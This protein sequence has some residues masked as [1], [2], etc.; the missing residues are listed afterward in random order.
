MRSSAGSK[1]I[2]HVENCRSSRTEG[3][4]QLHRISFKQN[5]LVKAVGISMP[6]SS[7]SVLELADFD[8][9]SNDCSGYCGVL[10]PKQSRLQDVRV[11]RVRFSGSANRSTAVFYASS[12]SR[13]SVEYMN[14]VEN[15]CSLLHIKGGSLNLWNVSF[16]QNPLN[17]SA[18]K[19]VNPCIRLS[20]ASALIRE[21]RFE[22]NKA[23]IG[24]AIVTSTSNVT[25]MNTSFERNAA[26]QGGIMV[27][28]DSSSALIQSCNF[29][30]NIADESGGV[31]LAS[32]SRVI[33]E[34]STLKENRA[35]QLGGC[36]CLKSRSELEMRQSTLKKNEANFGGI[37]HLAKHSMANLSES[38]LHKNDAVTSGGCIYLGVSRLFVQKC[39]F[40]SGSAVYGGGIYASS[41]NV[42]VMK[43][44]VSKNNASTSGGFVY[45]N[46]SKLT[47][48]NCRVNDGCAR[49]GGGICAFS[50]EISA[51]KIIA[52]RNNAKD[53][54][55]FFCGQTSEVRTS[56][57]SYTDNVATTGGGVTECRP[58]CTFSDI[59]SNYSRNAADFG[60]AIYLKQNATGSISDCRFEKNNASISGGGVY[61]EDSAVLS[62][63]KCHFG[64]GSAQFGGGIYAFF[65]SVSVVKT[66]VSRNNVSDH[67]G[68]IYGG[69]TELRLSDC[70]YIDNVAGS[71]GGVVHCLP[72]CTYSDMRSNYSRNTAPMG[73]SIYLRQN[74]SGSITECTFDKNNASISGGVAHIEG[75][76]LF[77]RKC[78]FA[79]G[80]AHVGGGISLLYS[81]ISV[82]K[83]TASGL[84][85]TETGGF[86]AG[87]TSEIVINDCSFLN[88]VAG[89]GGVLS[90]DPNC[91]LNLKRSNCSGNAADF[92]A[93]LYL[94]A[95]SSGRI[96]D[97][98]FEKN[99]ASTSGG[100]AYLGVSTLSVQKCRFVSGSA[101]YGGGICA[102]DSNV[103]II[104][105]TSRRSNA[106]TSGGFVYL[107]DSIFSMQ[108][109]RLVNGSANYGGGIYAFS[110][111]VSVMET[112]AQGNNA[113]EYGGGIYVTDSL[114]FVRRCRFVNGSTDYG[115]GICAYDSN[116]SIIETTSRRSNASTSGGF[117]YLEDSIFSM[118]KCRLVNGSANYGG[119]IY[120]FSSNVS[121]METTAQ[122]N[123]ASEYGGGIY[124]T[125]SLLFVRRCRFVNGSTD[126]GGGICAYDSNV[127]IIET[128]SRRSNASTSGG[129]VYLEDSIFSMQKCRLV[130]GSAN[131]GGGICAYDSNVSVIETTASNNIAS[132]SGGFVYLEDSIFSMQ[133]CRLVNGSANYGGGIYAASSKISVSETIASSLSANEEG[134]FI[135]G[136]NAE[137]LIRDC[138]FVHNTAT[139]AGGVIRCLKNS[140]LVVKKSNYSHN[141]AS[142]GGAIYLAQNSSGRLVNSGFDKNTARTSGGAAYIESSGL[143]VQKC[144][145]TGGSA[146]HGGGIYG[147]SL[148]GISIH[149]TKA[150]NMSALE[151]G[152]FIS[153][154]FLSSAV[155]VRSSVISATAQD[156]GAVHVSSRSKFK[157]RDIRISSC[158]AE[159]N[160]GA[161]YG[162]ASHF[163]CINCLVENNNGRYGGAI[164]SEYSDPQ[165][166]ELQLEN[167]TIRNNSAVFGGI[168]QIPHSL[169]SNLLF[170]GGIEVMAIDTFV[171]SNRSIG[172]DDCYAAALIDNV[173]EE[174][175]ATVAGGAVFVD[176]IAVIRMHCS[177]NSTEDELSFLSDEQ[178]KQMKVLNSTEDIC[179]TWKAN[180]AKRYG[181]DVASYA[182]DV[183]KI[184]HSMPTCNISAVKNQY[185]VHNYSSG[186]PLPPVSLTS[187][188]DLGQH[189]AFGVDN[190]QVAAVMS[191]PDGLFDGNIS[192]RLD[193][194]VESFTTIGFAEPG[195]YTVVIDFDQEQCES[196]KIVVEV[197]SCAMGE[198]PFRNGTLCE[199]CSSSTYSLSLEGDSVCHPCPENG[200][201]ETRVILPN[202]GYW[203]RTPCSEHIDRCIAR[204]ACVG[205][206]RQQELVEATKEVETCDFDEQY[207]QN[208]TE[209]QCREVRQWVLLRGFEFRGFYLQGHEGPLCGSC[210]E[211]CGRSHSFLCQKCFSDTGNVILVC[212]SF[213][214][215]MGLSAITIRSNL[216]SAA[217]LLQQPQTPMTAS[218]AST[219][220]HPVPTARCTMELT[221]MGR[222]EQEVLHHAQGQSVDLVRN[223]QD[224][225]LAKWKAIEL[226]KVQIAISFF[227]LTFLGA[228]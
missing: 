18:T 56:D 165:S 70:L 202:G 134:G 45:L 113:S 89:R 200:N 181:P 188:D 102:Y 207:I 51:T 151:C 86:M 85:V 72:N 111:N 216:I 132:T 84:S 183:R 98:V 184:M 194:N 116:V 138:L 228:L 214:V 81:N 79:N 35:N 226:F 170:P 124:V 92:G 77:V 2:I 74:S 62:V 6:R 198:V 186:T 169:Y 162:R 30:Y 164:F 168:P 65:S 208:Y 209:V 178:L 37:V 42:C 174:N 120:A 172:K 163:L 182:A 223:P 150:S 155:M 100:F 109:C 26:T 73:G 103:S 146:K 36:F 193:S 94:K 60:G 48:E 180:T 141:A 123:N 137:I 167:S 63:Q 61:L 78:R 7:C 145:F 106:S 152:G 108:K 9:E 143:T 148:A 159:R 126:Y 31:L 55:G 227:V 192:R 222:P 175:T 41:S 47:I 96:I 219:S 224:P 58:N 144:R 27:L 142:S 127:S 46:D 185:I 87:G 136:K 112:T 153:I 154:G 105:T 1:A 206:D 190:Q 4:V 195:N 114:L 64:D 50:S 139:V 204:D 218:T 14:A 54:G 15:E 68:Y 129:F 23:R 110:S 69:T 44:T 187:I 90:C 115:G 117:V 49:Y 104:E 52:S 225:E 210:K 177:A 156:G 99:N 131:Y 221:S 157:A 171:S 40:V 83:T 13:T 213:L 5:V 179:R 25:L 118:Q 217:S 203:H 33:V 215:L 21:S 125:D 20:N 66:I 8:F 12:G 119:G 205:Q 38:V 59:R 76:V 147:L 80:S 57:C 199:P 97:C 3:I 201:C 130:N 91:S 191:S 101:D 197:R 39:R 161:L 95:N 17:S 28:R 122:G 212:L 29:S 11:R 160:G 67:G 82:T 133:K 166:L 53:R 10:L 43:T 220:S 22:G 107:E 19:T 135:S 71:E 158:R 34:D 176:R 196:I 16:T 88:N 211:S 149:Q 173:F 140:R 128:T 24:S 121:V 189:P 75:S 93:V 32:N